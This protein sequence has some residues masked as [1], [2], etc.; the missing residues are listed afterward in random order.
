MDQGRVVSWNPSQDPPRPPTG[1]S[2]ATASQPHP[3]EAAG[4]SFL[5]PGLR[6]TAATQ[7]PHAS[8]V[9]M[10]VNNCHMLHYRLNKGKNDPTPPAKADVELVTTS[11]ASAAVAAAAAP[12]SPGG[13]RQKGMLKKQLTY[14]SVK[15]PLNNRVQPALVTVTPGKHVGG[16]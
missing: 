13:S 11:T 2:P 4:T 8:T 10:S 3:T 1:D 7:Q 15:A 14:L 9:R 6:S 12:P 16:L 5:P